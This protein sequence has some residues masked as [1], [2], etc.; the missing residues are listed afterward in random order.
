MGVEENKAVVQKFVEAMSKGDATVVDEL[1]SDDFVMHNLVSGKDNDRNTVKQNNANAHIN[2][3]GYSVDI[4]DMI[5][6]DNK[7]N[8]R[9]TFR[10]KHT[11]DFHNIAPTGND[12]SVAR[13]VT[14]RLA[15]GYVVEGWVLADDHSLNQQLGALPPTEEIGK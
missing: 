8:V 2:L 7:V 15:G 3:S 14:F 9:Q 5:A 12:L 4:E 6:E 1:L 10:G 13:F 11:G